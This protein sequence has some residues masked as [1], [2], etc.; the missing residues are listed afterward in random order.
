MSE[1]AD[2]M[3]AGGEPV[4]VD[5]AAVIRRALQQWEQVLGECTNLGWLEPVLRA[6][7]LPVE[8]FALQART[9]MRNRGTAAAWEP[10]IRS[11]VQSGDPWWARQLLADAG[12]TSRELEALGIETE[13]ALHG[14]SSLISAWVQEHSDQ[15]AI[16]AAI[17]W[18]V[19]SG[20]IDR[21][22]QL[23][24]Q[25]SGAD[26]WRARFALWRNQPATARRLLQ[27]LQPTAEV[28]C[29]QAIAAV[30]DGEM[31]EADAL[32]SKLLAGES[33]AEALNWLAT[34]RRMQRRYGEAVRAA[35][36]ANSASTMFN[37]A[38]RIEHELS[39]TALGASRFTRLLR[40]FGFRVRTI[41]ELEYAD[42]L[43]PFGLKPNDRVEELERVL[44]R[45]AGNHS[46][47]PTTVDQ[48]SLAFH[49]L[50]QDPR[51]LGASIQR[52]LFTRGAEAVRDLYR[53]LAPTVQSHP[54][55]L[56]YQG[57]IELWLGA[58]E[59]A[60]RI[61]H[62]AL[63]RDR[64]TRWAWIGLG[65]SQLFQGELRAAQDTWS[66][67]VAET[68]MN[69]P[70]L[71]IYRGE[72]FR[73]QGNTREARKDLL[74]AAAQRPQR[75][76]ALINLALLD[77]RSEVT[78]QAQQACRTFAPLLMRELESSPKPLEDVLAAMRG[79]RSSLPSL[80]SYH[81]WGHVW[82]RAA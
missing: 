67:G 45:F 38:I 65:A 75:L 61:F 20:R 68:G 42:L 71:F 3:A 12:C 62:D 8:A 15:A 25:F 18:W 30:L 55:F 28:R 13:L 82:R 54:L 24:A 74:H 48:E 63:A 39:A 40:L 2:A 37:L 16:G 76:S 46:P 33:R 80:Q 1:S 14:T 72:C 6:A 22:E 29:L 36:D 9:L 21:A 69:G 10:F 53:T 78:H 27:D 31:D 58:Y 34:V 79:N 77:E 51:F 56:I 66:K 57:E 19:R 73:R 70:T 50:P 41:G 11:V 17:D 35:D 26:L 52:V 23:L 5:P 44:Q 4:G 47:W 60:A 32:L 7:G 49:R 81:L 59:D 64:K 43:Y